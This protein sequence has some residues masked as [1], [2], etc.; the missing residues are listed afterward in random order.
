MKGCGAGHAAVP[1]STPS[2]GATSTDSGM[3]PA[4]TGTPYTWKPGATDTLDMLPVKDSIIAIAD[5]NYFDWPLLPEAPSSL[6]AA[7]SGTSTKLTWDVHGGDPNNV[8]VERKIWGSDG[9]RWERLTT[10]P[11]TAKD[12][13]D[14]SLKRGQ[15]AAY[16][17]RATT[18]NGTSAYSNIVRVT[19][20]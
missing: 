8:I 16:R 20:K 3:N 5:E 13:T 19:L 6:E 11:A 17:I 2:I 9:D 10:L 12:Y 1:I 18:T 7:V 4:G 15:R 14:S